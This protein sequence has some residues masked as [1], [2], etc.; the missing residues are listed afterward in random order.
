ME[1]ISRVSSEEELLQLRNE[2]KISETEYSELLG[3]MKKSPPSADDGRKPQSDAETSRRRL[4]KISFCLMLAGFG[5]P[6]VVFF[7][8]FVISAV[9]GLGEMDVVFTGCLIGCVLLEIPAFVFGVISW[10]D[11]LG[12]ATVAAISAM[13]VL[14]LLFMS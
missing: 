8:S 14:A 4:G 6:I 9:G 3:A 12:K 5:L 13:A 11:V 1:G 2:G 7:V 10:P